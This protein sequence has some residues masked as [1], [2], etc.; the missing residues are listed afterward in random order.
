[1]I[2]RGD[3]LDINFELYKVF[4]YVAKSLSFSQAATELYISQS[5]VSQSIKQL[6]TKLDCLLLARS[7]K[8]VKLTV[9]GQLLFTHVEQ[10]YNFIKGGER[11]LGALQ[12]LTQG[13]V[14]LGAT[15][16]ICKHF[17]LPFLREYRRLY[18][19][20]NL[21]I[22]TRTSPGCLELLEKGAVDLIV[23][24]LPEQPP[25]PTLRVVTT[26]PLQDI[27]VASP[28]LPGLVTGQISFSDLRTFPLLL[29]EKQ[30]A[31][32]DFLDKLLHQHGVQIQ[33][34]IELDSVDLLIELAKTGL[35]I[36]Y[37][38]RDYVL[39]SLQRGELV[40]IHTKEG[41]PKRSLGIITQANIPLPPAAE[42]LLSLLTSPDSDLKSFQTAAH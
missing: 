22:T 33:P 19:G 16:T 14:R 25:A 40:E 11:Q 21:H 31:T 2:I 13:E 34:E 32:R 5:A 24:N 30:T 35:G 39:D 1:M 12:A 38:V 4:Y 18:P 41:I 17:L 29:L 36:T 3:N 15:D 7:T 37:V 20:I 23:V 27:F 10:A 8:Q 28:E 42:Q 26:T 9:Q 6:E